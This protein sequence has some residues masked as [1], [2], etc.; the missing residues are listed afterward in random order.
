MTSP[1]WGKNGRSGESSPMPNFTTSRHTGREIARSFGGH[2]RDTRCGS[3]FQDVDVTA[4]F[5]M[6]RLGPRSLQGQ[7]A[8]ADRSRR[9]ASRDLF[10]LASAGARTGEGKQGARA[11][12]D[13]RQAFAHF[14]GAADGGGSGAAGL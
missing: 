3:N 4:I 1:R 11:G 12:G 6:A 8:G 10:Q 9:R 14:S 2:Q 7:R 5:A 13:R